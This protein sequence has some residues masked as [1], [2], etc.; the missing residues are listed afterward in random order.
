MK[1][2]GTW[3]HELKMSPQFFGDLIAGRKKFEIRKD[4]RGGFH[5]DQVIF[6]REFWSGPGW[7]GRRWI[8]LKITYVLRE[9][10]KWGVA[11]GHAVFGV[12]VLDHGEFS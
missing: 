6:A 8:L 3:D 4:D 9:P 11:P 7:Y 10:E 12:A 2:D 5:Q 1:A